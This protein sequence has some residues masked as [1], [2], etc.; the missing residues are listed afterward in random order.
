MRKYDYRELSLNLANHIGHELR[1]ENNTEKN[2][3]V[4]ICPSCPFGGHSIINLASGREI[5]EFSPKEKHSIEK[6]LLLAALKKVF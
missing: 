5:A 6:G 3:L 1:L 2:T 4:L